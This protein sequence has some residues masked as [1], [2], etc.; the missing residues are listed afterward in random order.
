[1]LLK[2]PCDRGSTLQPYDDPDFIELHSI[3][4]RSS[5][6]EACGGTVKVIASIEDPQVIKQI[7]FHLE[8]KAVSRNS[9]SLPESRAPPPVYLPGLR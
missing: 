4:R 3:D 8:Q 1:M 9:R 2:N 7:L 5:T 6:C